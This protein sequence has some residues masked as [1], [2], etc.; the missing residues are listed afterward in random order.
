[1]SA[2]L[3]SGQ[4]SQYVG[5]AKEIYENYNSAKELIDRADEI[6]GNKISEIMFEGPAEKLTETRYTQL[7]IFLHSAVVFN[8][9]K[10]KLDIDCFA[11][12]SVGELAAL[13]A[14][15]VI[16]F[17]AAVKLVAKRGELMFSAGLEKPG[18]MF[19]IIGLDDE[20][21]DELCDRFN[22]PE[23]DKIVVPANYNSPGQIVISGSQDYLREIAPLFKENGAKLVKELNVSGAFHS[24]LLDLAKNE[25]SKLID[26]IDF[27]NAKFPVFTNVDANSENSSDEL[28]RKLKE[29]IVSPVR[30]SQSL[31]AMKDSGVSKFLEIGPGKVLQG[32]VKRTLSD[33][34]IS[35]VDSYSDIQNFS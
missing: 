5:M 29:Q 35:G 11:G 22:K 28:K 25:F 24:P 9:L 8:I 16:D 17:E 4:G 21:V 10:D 27:N 2:I 33:V 6:L 1:M 13:F 7:A 19:A 15:R 26:S 12:H 3:F 31:V 14:A 32:L 23:E 20:K 30:W 34:Q 18:T